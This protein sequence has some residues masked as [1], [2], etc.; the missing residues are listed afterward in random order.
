MELIL[1]ILFSAF[2][3]KGTC[4]SSNTKNIHKFFFEKKKE[5]PELFKNIYFRETPDYVFSKD[6]VKYFTQLQ[7]ADY[8]IRTNIFESLY[9]INVNKKELNLLNNKDIEIISKQ[10]RSFKRL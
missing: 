4:F 6:I 2:P 9:K 7:E 3:K 5:H 10:F 8:L 1:S